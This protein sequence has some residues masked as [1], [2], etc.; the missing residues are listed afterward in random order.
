M[1]CKE[2]LWKLFERTGNVE[3][4]LLWKAIDGGGKDGRR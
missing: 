3:Y 2:T 4:Y 1:D